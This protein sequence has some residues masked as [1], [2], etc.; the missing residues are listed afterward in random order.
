M[1][2]ACWYSFRKFLPEVDFAVD[3]SLSLPIFRWIPRISAR[4]IAPR[5][6]DLVVSTTVM[7]VRDFE[8]DWTV[9][10]SK[11]DDQTCLVDYSAGCGNFV[12]DKWININRV[13]FD[14]ALKR[15]GVAGMTVNESAVLKMFERCEALYR[16]V[17]V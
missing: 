2:F 15:L 12:V 16:T 13:P 4:S 7:A 1:A 10:S 3:V 9:S 11:S 5:E 14:R 6:G 8:G 17:G